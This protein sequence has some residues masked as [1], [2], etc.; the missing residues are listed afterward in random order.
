MVFAG[1]QATGECRTRLS[2]ALSLHLRLLR[3]E[4]WRLMGANSDMDGG[5]AEKKDLTVRTRKRFSSHSPF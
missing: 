4:I 1:F 2:V 3:G 5:K